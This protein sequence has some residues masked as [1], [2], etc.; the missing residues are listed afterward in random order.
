MKPNLPK[1]LTFLLLFI[2]FQS[3]SQEIWHESFSI[4]EKGVWGDNE[5]SAIHSDFSE[6]E[7]WTLDYSNII[8]SNEDDY[9]KTVTTSGGRFECRDIN[10]EVIWRSESIDISAYKNVKIQLEASETGSGA[11]TE[12]KYLKVYSKIDE[13]DEILFETNGENAGNWGSNT[14]EQTNLNGNKLQIMVYLNNHY[15]ADKVIL[16]E[17]VV[18]G[19]ELNPVTI[20]AGDILIN[21]IL[22][23]PVPNGEDYVEIYNNSGKIIPLNKLY[24]AS[25]DN[26]LNLTQIYALSNKRVKLS[27][28]EYLALTKDTLG[29]FP[30]FT[31]NCPICFLQMERFPSFNNDQDYV[32]LL[33]S[34]MEIIDEFWYNEKMH[35]PLLYDYEG[36]SLERISFSEKTNAP[37][38]WHSA[39]TESGYGTPGYKNSQSENHTLNKVLVTFEP[40]AF[41]PNNDGYND[42]YSINFTFDK[43]GY[44]ANIRIFD[45]SGRL[46]TQLSKN[47][48]L[49]ITDQIKWNGEDETGQQQPI[50]AYIVLVE[51]F[52]TEGFMKKFKDGVI[53]TDIFD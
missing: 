13:S 41:S 45:S 25:R 9:A 36:I 1:I 16:D 34:D 52:N 24:L 10:S 17:I 20:E 5:G 46:V 33:N 43:P 48:I 47:S 37:S 7:K 6:I 53:L 50:G 38:N 8:L 42:I 21:E 29:V 15:S 11:N 22:F 28:T 32:V 40:E 19:E 26:D 31:I 23:N 2:S 51:V 39:S 27:P 14:A 12:T 4:P 35:M 49:G 3:H 44:V 18:S 30:W